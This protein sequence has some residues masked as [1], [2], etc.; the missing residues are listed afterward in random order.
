[1]AEQGQ[2][3]LRQR[4]RTMERLQTLDKAIQEFEQAA[5][6]LMEECPP[7][8]GMRQDAVVA[9]QW[10]HRESAKQLLVKEEASKL[11][12]RLAELELTVVAVQDA[13]HNVDKGIAALFHV[14]QV[15]TAVQL[16]QRLRMDERCLVLRKE[17]REIQLR[18]ES[19]RGSDEQAQ[20][21]ELLSAYDEASLSSLLSEQQALLEQEEARRT[22][23]LDKRGRLSQELERQRSEAELEDNGQRLRELQSKLELLTERYAILAITDRLIV[24]TKAVYEEEKQ[25]IVLQRASLYFHQ[26]TNGAYTRI[27]APS[28]SKTLYAETSD[29]R[30]LDS[31]FLSRGTQEQLYL[32]MRFAL[33]DA[34]SPEHPLPLLL[35]DLFVHFDEQRLMH[36]LPVLEKLGQ[37]R[38]VILFTCHRHV[39]QT[40]ASGIPSARM[41]TLG[42][43]MTLVDKSDVFDHGLSERASLS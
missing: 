23:L 7:P 4:Q 29:H 5:A 43:K 32:A 24:Q 42:E 34:A 15:E 38:Q 22:E 36:T 30:M 16:E 21:Y 41:L 12:R 39:A 37:A 9:V 25:P 27:V 2:T 40:I 18:L 13:L 26:M 11:D 33:C 35:D 10:L 19:G 31:L 14:A 28:D 1:M 20:L 17:A 3:M 8:V 6:R